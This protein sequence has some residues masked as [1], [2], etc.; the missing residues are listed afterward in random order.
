MQRNAERRRQVA[1]ARDVEAGESANLIAHQAPKAAKTKPK[2]TEAKSKEAK[3]VDAPTTTVTIHKTEDDEMKKEPSVQKP[4]SSF[5]P[6]PKPAETKAPQED[7]TQDS[8][9]GSEGTPPTD[10]KTAP[11]MKQSSI[12]KP[13]HYIPRAQ[14]SVPY[15]KKK[16]QDSLDQVITFSETVLASLQRL[17]RVS[18][19]VQMIVA[20]GWKLNVDHIM[21]K[22]E[23]NIL[24][25]HVDVATDSLETLIRQLDTGL[26]AHGAQYGSNNTNQVTWE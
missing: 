19:T 6:A 11:L 18:P 12:F 8:P 7:R 21:S 2:A 3:S 16:K 10:Q 13:N 14:A 15:K 1:N 4:A 26:L 9:T 25:E 24:R 17:Q 20:G 23:K 22:L 5:E